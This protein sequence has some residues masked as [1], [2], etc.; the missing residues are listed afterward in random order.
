LYVVLLDDDKCVGC[1]KC[2]T[3]C[4]GRVLTIVSGKAEVQTGECL[5]C[6]GCV[7]LCPVGAVTLEEY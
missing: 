3:A 5:G 4:P 7:L 1:G 6:Q 2:V